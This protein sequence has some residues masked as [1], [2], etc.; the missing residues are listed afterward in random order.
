MSTTTFVTP[1]GGIVR[2]EQPLTGKV[3]KLDAGTKERSIGWALDPC[4]TRRNID[5]V[6]PGKISRIV[7]S[8]W[9][10]REEIY[11]N[12]LKESRQAWGKKKKYPQQ[13]SMPDSCLIS[14]SWVLRFLLAVFA[15]IQWRQD[16]PKS[17]NSRCPPCWE[18]Y[19]LSSEVVC[20]SLLCSSWLMNKG[21]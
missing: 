4:L 21:F 9:E 19:R 16:S 10:A 15:A 17:E 20:G 7:W 13:K 1:A 14:E 8:K 12:A 11:L 2:T 5:F 6:L 3:A 18:H